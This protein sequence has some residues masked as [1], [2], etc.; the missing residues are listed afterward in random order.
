[1]KPPA[2]PDPKRLRRRLGLSESQMATAIGYTSDAEDMNKRRANKATAWRKLANGKR[3]VSRV[4]GRLLV[5]FERFGVPDDFLIPD[6]EPAENMDSR[7]Q[8]EGE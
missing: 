3:P 1:M 5:M 4:L 2:P 6:D 7:P 8:N